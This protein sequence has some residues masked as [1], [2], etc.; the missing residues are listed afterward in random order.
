MEE[1]ILHIEL[2]NGPVM[3]DSSGEHRANGGRFHNRAESLIVVDSGA[4]SETSK[5]PASL[6]AIE[7]PISAELVR[8]DPFAGDDVGALRSWN[9]VPDPIAHQGP[10]LVLHSRTPIGIDEGSADGGRDRGR[11]RRRS[12]GGEDESIRQHSEAILCPCD[13]PMRILRRR[14]RHHHALTSRGRWPK[15]GWWSVTRGGRAAANDGRR[16]SARPAT[17]EVA[18]PPGPQSVQQERP[19]LRVAPQ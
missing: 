1:S 6:V 5:D 12:R 13:H 19:G 11:C 2:L 7:G 14:D 15:R 17:H 8:E 18:G 4:L 16:R 10:V 9:K 3:G